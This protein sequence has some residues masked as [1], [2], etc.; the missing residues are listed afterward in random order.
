M[1]FFTEEKYQNGTSHSEYEK[2][3]RSIW[4][5]LGNEIKCIN[6]GMLPEDMLE[7]LAAIDLHD[8]KIIGFNKTSSFLEI[9][10]NT[11]NHGGLRKVWL[12]YLCPNI[13]ELP[14]NNVLGNNIEHRDSDV[15][16]HEI[17]K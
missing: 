11:D 16:C 15:M 1:K 12:K 3:C 13:V 5:E 10:F 7:G 9:E 8:S 4:N 17:Y 14:S 2:Y 6:T